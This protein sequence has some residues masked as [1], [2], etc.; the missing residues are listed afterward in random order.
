MSPV[1]AANN[2]S[3]I[4]TGMLGIYGETVII[5][6]GMG[7]ATLYGHLSSISVGTGDSV[8]RGQVIGR[9]GATGLAGGDHLH[10]EFRLHGVPVYPIEWLDP[11]W[12]KDHVTDQLPFVVK[13]IKNILALSEPPK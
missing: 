1:M 13:Q 8:Q 7:L 4:F 10:I 11:H 3:V 5:D 12:M 9:S 2:G 6:H